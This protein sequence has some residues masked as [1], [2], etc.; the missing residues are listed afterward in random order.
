MVTQNIQLAEKSRFMFFSGLSDHAFMCVT[1][2]NLLSCCC[3]IL[4]NTM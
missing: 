3:V 4:C 1:I 2:C